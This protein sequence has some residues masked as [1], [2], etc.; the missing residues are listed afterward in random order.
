MASGKVH[1]SWNDQME[2]MLTNSR[3]KDIGGISGSYTPSWVVGE[4]AVIS[5]QRAHKMW[6]AMEAQK[7][8]LGSDYKGDT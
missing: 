6:I 4:S 5:V 7:C 3:S 2:K 8:V 1:R